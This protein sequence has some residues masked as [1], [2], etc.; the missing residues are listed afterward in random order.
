MNTSD[1]YTNH[2]VLQLKEQY[3]N[4]IEFLQSKI[5]SQQNEI[6]QLK[7]QI[8]LITAEKMYEC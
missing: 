7:E 6:D 2:L 4:R 8:K 1:F 3:R 5:T